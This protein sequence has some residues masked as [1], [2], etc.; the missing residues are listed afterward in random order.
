VS[1]H[2]IFKSIDQLPDRYQVRDIEDDNSFVSINVSD[3]NG[4]TL[5]VFVLTP[6]SKRREA[7]VYRTKLVQELS[8]RGEK[9]QVKMKACETSVVD[10]VISKNK[11]ESTK[12][13]DGTESSKYMEAFDEVIEAIVQQGNTSDVHFEYTRGIGTEVKVRV[14]GQLIP[15][16]TWSGDFGDSVI[17]VLFR[18]TAKETLQDNSTLDASVDRKIEGK[19]YKLRLNYRPT[20]NGHDTVIRIQHLGVTN[21]L[22]FEDAGYSRPNILQIRSAIMV[23]QRLVLLVG[24]TGSGKSTTMQAML[25]EQ[26]KRDPYKKVISLEDPVEFVIPGVRQTQIGPGMTFDIFLESSMRS[27]PDTIVMGE[28]RC[29]STAGFV[30]KGTL[31]GHKMYGTMH[32]NSVFAVFPRLE[33]IGVSRTIMASKEF[34]GA[35]ICQ[36]LL[37]HVCPHCSVPM[38]SDDERVDQFGVEHEG[39]RAAWEATKTRWDYVLDK[40]KKLGEPGR[41]GIPSKG[42]IRLSNPSG[43]NNCRNGKLSKRSIAAE[44]LTPDMTMLEFIK[45]GDDFKAWK[46]WRENGGTTKLD[47][48]IYKTLVGEI[49]PMTCE[50][51]IDP[52]TSD[53]VHEDG[54]IQC[55]E[56]EI[57]GGYLKE[58]D[59]DQC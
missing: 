10:D 18:V 5:S 22:S 3:D 50:R 35:I 19:A 53:E 52:V 57:I 54:I 24:T 2:N 6:G 31:T 55:S 36:K 34:F 40:M 49:C 17:S 41:R 37:P 7:A 4:N 29:P 25:V 33:K 44:V 8:S 59:E 47:H 28:V 58:E 38:Y 13:A 56:L 48:A 46:H 39:G 27:D 26:I 30:E 20:F 12:E 14:G 15:F 45:D 16:R 1:E 23:P 42:N 11:S 32:A 51:E 43:C 21:I 9:I